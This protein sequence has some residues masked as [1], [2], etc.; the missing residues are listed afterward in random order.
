MILRQQKSETKD[1]S[2]EEEKHTEK[3]IHSGEKVFPAGL[4]A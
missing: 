2:M 4:G 1:Y 3:F